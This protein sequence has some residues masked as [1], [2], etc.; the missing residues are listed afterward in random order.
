MA[1]ASGSELTPAPVPIALGPVMIENFFCGNFTHGP[2]E[3]AAVGLS[4]C[5]YLFMLVLALVVAIQ[6]CRRVH[7]RR[8]GGMQNGHH[9][10]IRGQNLRLAVTI[11]LTI[12]LVGTLTA[13]RRAEFLKRR[14]SPI[15]FFST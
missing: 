13:T 3:F 1:D 6:S 14:R 5:L 8:E 11:S 4:T 10:V 15:C 12:F 2:P 9:A 7:K